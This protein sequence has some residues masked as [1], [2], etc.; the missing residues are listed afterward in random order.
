MTPLA[1]LLLTLVGMVISVI[2]GTIWYSDATPMGRVHMR[3]L[4][5]DKLSKEEKKKM[6]EKA[7]PQ[8]PKMYA[9]QMALSLLTSFAVVFIV[10]TSLI[11]GLS[12]GMSLGF[13]SLNWLC[14]MV[15]LVGSGILWGN[16]DPS[17]AWKKFFSDSLE[18]LLMVLLI[19]L[20]TSLFI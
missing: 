18:N 16:C 1:L 11:N 9:A 3:Y 4:G 2:L 5:F 10:S 7:K 19:G 8:M 13:V 12:L 14:F 17:L 20:M 6:M 15:P